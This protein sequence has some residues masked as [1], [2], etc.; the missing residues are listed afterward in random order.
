MRFP[1][2]RKMMLFIL[3]PIG[4]I[5]FLFMAFD[6]YTMEKWVV[7]ELEERMVELASGYADQFD[8]YL[9]EVSQIAKSTATFIENR[10]N[11]TSEQIFAQLGANVQQNQLV[12]GAAMGFEPYQYEAGRRLF[13]P[14]VYREKEGLLQMDIGVEGYDYTQPQWKWWNKPKLHNKAVW[15]DP[16]FDEDASVMT[17]KALEMMMLWMSVISPLK[18]IPK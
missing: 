11:I 16:Y 18:I 4:L 14:Y 2:R 3:I 10:P 15:T 5:Y 8:G 6:V 7:V 12:Y 1:I 17:R 13:A 9:R